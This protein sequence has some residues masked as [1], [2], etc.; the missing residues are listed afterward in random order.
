MIPLVPSMT[1]YQTKDHVFVE[2]YLPEVGKEIFLSSCGWRESNNELHFTSKNTSESICYEFRKSLF[3]PIISIFETKSSCG[4][5][6]IKLEKKVETEWGRLFADAG[7][8]RNH[9]KINWNCWKNLS[10]ESDAS[11]TESV[12]SDE[13]QEMI[14]S[15]VLDNISTDE[16]SVLSE[17]STDEES[18]LETPSL[19]AT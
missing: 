4:K 13:L 19:Q 14:K 2:I 6:H 16:D 5:Y 10:S 1:W 11:E 9:V 7:F 12:D 8:N 18:H 15:G 3:A 17:S